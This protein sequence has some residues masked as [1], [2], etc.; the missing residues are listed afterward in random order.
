M[1]N[2]GMNLASVSSTFNQTKPFVAF[3]APNPSVGVVGLGVP[4]FS[5]PNS[6]V[7]LGTS[8]NVGVKPNPTFG[9]SYKIN[10]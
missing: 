9:V 5:T 3:T 1:N 10:L 4:V 2:L 7:G 6:T 8:F